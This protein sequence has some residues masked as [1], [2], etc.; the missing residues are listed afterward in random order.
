MNE[1]QW[2]CDVLAMEVLLYYQNVNAN[3]LKQQGLVATITWFLQGMHPDTLCLVFTIVFTI[4]LLASNAHR[5]IKHK[6]VTP[7]TQL[8]IDNSWRSTTL[9]AADSASSNQT[10]P[11]QNE[12]KWVLEK[13]SD[14]WIIRCHKFSSDVLISPKVSSFMWFRKVLIISK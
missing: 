10:L 7:T 6:F 13:N 1:L 4:L 12:H 11:F 9:P 2:L 3:N 5:I 14:N 8:C